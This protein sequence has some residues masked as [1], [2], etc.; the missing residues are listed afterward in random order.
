MFHKHWL[1][2]LLLNVLQFALY[3]D[4]KGGGKGSGSKSSSK[5]SKSSPNTIVHSSNGQCYNEQYAA[6]SPCSIP[7]IFTRRQECPDQMS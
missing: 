5:G 4:A 1:F 3:V 6:Q 2:L 7:L